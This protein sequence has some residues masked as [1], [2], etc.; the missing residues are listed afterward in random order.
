MK[1]PL[2][3]TGKNTVLFND[4]RPL[5]KDEVYKEIVNMKPQTCDIDPMPTVMVKKTRKKSFTTDA[6]DRKLFFSNRR[7]CITVESC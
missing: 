5:S 4:F 1:N 3:Q 2:N 6:G 7:I